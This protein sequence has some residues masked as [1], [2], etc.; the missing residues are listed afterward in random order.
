[1]AEMLR[2]DIEKKAAWPFV[3]EFPPP[4]SIPVHEIG[5]IA[6]PAQGVLS[7]IFQY[8]V[9][10]GFNFYL[11]RVLEDF[12]GGPVNPGDALWTVDQNAPLPNVQG[13]PVQGLTATPTPLGS[14]LTGLK[15]KLPRVYEFA[16]LTLLRSTVVNQN[17]N[18]GLPN[19]FISGFFGYLL[20]AIVQK[21]LY[22]VSG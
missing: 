21:R 9:P 8:R 5:D 22:A 3:H 10:K 12:S 18:V 6:S 15:W 17:L 4:G 2:R 11:C 13:M 14:F 19:V 20:P 7:V 1:M 16:P